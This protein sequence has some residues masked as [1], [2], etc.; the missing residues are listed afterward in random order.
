MAH[1]TGHLIDFGQRL[2]SMIHHPE[3]LESK[4][5]PDPMAT[6][7]MQQ[8]SLLVTPPHLA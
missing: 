3:H 4:V 5:M 6:F 7:T 8:A 2:G 1:N